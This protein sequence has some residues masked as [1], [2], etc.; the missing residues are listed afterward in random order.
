MIDRYSGAR[1]PLHTSVAP[2]TRVRWSVGRSIV[3]YRG[4]G[5]K[6]PILVRA[7]AIRQ[8]MTWPPAVLARI[9]EREHTDR[10]Q[11]RNTP[12][13]ASIPRMSTAARRHAPEAK[14]T[15]THPAGCLDR[16]KKA[17]SKYPA[18]LAAATS[19]S[20]SAAHLAVA[21]CT[22]VYIDVGTHEGMQIEKL[23][24]PSRFPDAPVQPIFNRHFGT[25]RN[26]VCAY[27]IEPNPVHHARLAMLTRRYHPRLTVVHAAASTT[28]GTATFWHNANHAN[29]SAHTEWSASLL[30][31][32]TTA[33]AESFNVS[34]VDLAEFVLSHTRP[35]AASWGAGLADRGGSVVMKLDIEGAEVEVLP[36]LVERGALCRVS[37]LYMEVHSVKLVPKVRG[38]NVAYC[39]VNQFKQPA[40]RPPNCPYKIVQLDDEATEK[41]RVG[42]TSRER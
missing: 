27:A 6:L 8:R 17:K 34:T 29:G 14:R 19:S 32:D 1:A 23:F 28:N 33:A 22:H 37:E 4:F 12:S 15:P 11:L 40:N 21:G 20:L 24:E 42:A 38:A 9:S 2:H 16:V 30:R 26:K 7:S 18:L 25:S 35:L 41:D 36:D 3:L 13:I 5:A 31:Y 39:L 10:G